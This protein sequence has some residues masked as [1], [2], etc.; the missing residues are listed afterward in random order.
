[1]FFKIPTTYVTAAILKAENKKSAVFR[2]VTP[3]NLVKDS[4]LL[5]DLG[6]RFFRNVGNF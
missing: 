4:S 3:C 6:D 5:K 1:M 2:D